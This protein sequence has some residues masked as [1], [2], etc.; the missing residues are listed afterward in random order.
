MKVLRSVKSAAAVFKA[1][2]TVE[3]IRNRGFIYS[4]LSIALWMS[5]FL[6]PLSL[7]T[8]SEVSKSQV[9]ATAFL[10]AAMMMAYSMATW[11]W[12]A[13]L[14]WLINGGLLEYIIASPAGFKELYLGVV[15]VSLIWISTAMAFIYL[16]LSAVLAPPVF[17]LIDPLALLLGTATLIIVLLAY[18]MIL[19][20]TMI[21]SGV[22]G[23]V[24]ELVSFILPLAS[25]AL[26]PLRSMPGFIRVVALATPFSYPSELLRYS[27]LGVQPA[28]ELT[29]TAVIGSLYTTLFLA[30]SIIYFRIQVRNMLRE[31]AKT[32]SIW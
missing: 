7:F 18:G 2:F 6:A 20:G 9:S 24:I 12:G 1:Y 22:S 27:L 26:V 21:S 8:S 31:G 13:E 29:T 4:L 14:R 23:P 10:T 28:L 19:G 25:G 16:W 11:D 32:A 3:F 30:G 15:P 17:A 5:L